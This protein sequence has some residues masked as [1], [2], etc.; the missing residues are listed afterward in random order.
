MDVQYVTANV[1]LPTSNQATF[2]AVCPAGH[3]L[4]AGGGG[5]TGG[6]IAQNLV[7][8]YNGPTPGLETTSWRLVII[9]TS[10]SD[11]AVTGYAICAKVQ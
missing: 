7:T 1:N 10:G 4:I 2:D 5:Y 9:N 6:G 11:K 8:T 3:K